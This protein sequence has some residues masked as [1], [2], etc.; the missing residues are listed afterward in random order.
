MTDST[1]S[2]APVGT[3]YLVGAG[4]GDPQLLTLGGRDALA[5]ADVVVYDRLANPLLLAHARA[6]AERIY[7]GKEAAEHALPQED[8]NALLAELALQGK[9]VC[10][11]KGGDP[12][13]FGRGGEEEAHLHARGVPVVV[14]P[15]ITSAIAV[16]AYAGIPVTDRRCASSFAVVTG[17][18]DADKS[19]ST[20]DWAGIAHGA[21]TLVFLMGL[22]A[23]P[24]IAAQL[25]ANGRPSATPAAAIHRGTTPR[26]RVVTGTLADIAEKVAAAGLRPPTITVVGEVVRLREELAWFDTRPL[27]GKRILVTRSRE[28]AS[29]MSRL[30][31]E[32][33]AE[34][35]EFPTI[36]ITPLPPAADLPAR[37]AADWLLFTSVNGLPCLLEQLAALGKDI[38]ALGT[39]KLGAIGPATADSLR[40]HGLRVDFVPERFIAEAVAEGLPD[41]AGQRIV[42][43]RA[44]EAREAL[45]ELLAARGASVEVVPVYRTEQE[46]GELPD[47]ATLD[48]ITFTSS[49]TVR[50]FRARVPG[51]VDAVIACIGPITAQ[52][53]EALGLRVDIVA[54]E[55]TLAGLIQ[56]LEQHFHK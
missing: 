52:T 6:D 1:Q 44:E 35:L 7:V 8:I 41:P 31:R 18:E 49:S 36:R 40:A 21:D 48:A 5:A 54:E 15:G 10:R 23:L 9:R 55:Y 3:V 29:D 24:T 46:A 13:V 26:Q 47:M 45:P 17:Q 53:A 38:R 22:S 50:N 2:S 37:L 56:A 20:L 19:D 34:A 42:L 14:I 32:A 27:F 33:G 51:E 43:L 4:P 28:Q 39:A 11:L 12:F 30:L 16:P 25:I